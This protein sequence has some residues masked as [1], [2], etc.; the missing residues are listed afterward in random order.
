MKQIKNTITKAEIAAMPKVQFPGRVFVIYTETEANKAI[1]F[2]KSQS[3][4]GVDTETRPSF[5]KGTSHKVALLQIS[6]TDTCFLFRLNQIGMPEALQEFLMSD[7]LKIGL[8]LKDDFMMLRR[9][10]DVHAEEGNWIELQDYV[11]RFGIEDRSLQ[12]IFANLFGQKIS[13]SQRLSNWEAETLSESQI[14]YAATDA[15]ACV[16][17]YNCLEEMERTGA[18]ELI[19]V[20]EPEK[21]LLETQNS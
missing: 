17:I 10:K 1:E 11:S 18:Y 15:W 4:V 13:K 6:T 8:S 14:K 7:V 21:E 20:V 19:K 5:K 3:I 9:R 2:L 16:E 12:K